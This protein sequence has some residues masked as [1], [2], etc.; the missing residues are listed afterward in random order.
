[1]KRPAV[2]DVFYLATDPDGY[3]PHVYKVQVL[4]S[5][6]S[7]GRMRQGIP[8]RLWTEFP[9][10]RWWRGWPRMD[11][12]R[13]LNGSWTSPGSGRGNSSWMRTWRRCMRTLPKKEE[14]L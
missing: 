1:M 4:E 3:C 12:C 11:W 8:I 14:T 10:R 7:R 5:T 2:G 9:P 6:H 13:R